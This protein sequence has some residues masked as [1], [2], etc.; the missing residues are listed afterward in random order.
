MVQLQ[1]SPVGNAVDEENTIVVV[2]TLTEQQG[3]D[4]SAVVQSDVLAADTAND[5]PLNNGELFYCEY[6]PVPNS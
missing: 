2:S 5:V 6:I 1:L 3:V 4:A